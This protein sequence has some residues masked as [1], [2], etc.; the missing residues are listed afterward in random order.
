MST[1]GYIGP[2]VYLTHLPPHMDN[3]MIVYN[4]YGH[5]NFG[6]NPKVKMC[7]R[8]RVDDLPGYKVRQAN[9]RVIYMYPKDIDLNTISYQVTNRWLQDVS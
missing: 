2:G 9:N 7:F 6:G 8:F 4:N 5:L 3:Q 1:G